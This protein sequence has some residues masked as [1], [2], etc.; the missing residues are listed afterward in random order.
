MVLLQCVGWCCCGGAE[1]S[2]QPSGLLGLL[3][4]L[5]HPALGLGVDDVLRVLLD[6]VSVGHFTIVLPAVFIVIP[7]VEVSL[8]CGQFHSGVVLWQLPLYTGMVL[9]HTAQ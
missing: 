5:G 7:I 6:G 1:T 8:G 3:L 2:S 9:K 4:L